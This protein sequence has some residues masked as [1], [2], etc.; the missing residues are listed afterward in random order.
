MPTHRSN[1]S[2]DGPDSR[3]I[4]P[5][6][7][8]APVQIGRYRILEHLGAGGMGVVYIALDTERNERV[9]LK[10]LQRM[11]PKGLLRLKNEFRSVA[12][13]IHPN[14]VVL[15]ELVGEGDD[16][17]FTMELVHGASFLDY[18]RGADL[19]RRTTTRFA[20]TVL[21]PT[22][23]QT[24]T[25][26]VLILDTPNPAAI[27]TPPPSKP[28]SPDCVDRLRTA[29]RQLAEGVSALHA[30]GK[31]HR[32]LK[33]SNVMV[34]S[35][36]RVV[37]LDFGLV[38]DVLPDKE[39]KRNLA[40]TPAYMAPELVLLQPAG[41]ASDWY[42]VGVMLYEALTGAVPHDSESPAKLLSDRALIIP[43]RP[44]I[45]IPGVPQDLD[46]L[47]MA[48]LNPDPAARPDAAEILARIGGPTPNPIFYKDTVPPP[49]AIDVIGRD[50]E[51]AVLEKALEVVSQGAP[52]T[53]YIGGRSGMGKSTL[54]ESFLRH[55]GARKDTLLLRG[56]CYERE[57]LPF[58]AF[59]SIIDAL[60]RF[61][62][63]LPESELRLLLPAH[64]RE[65]SRI[66]PVLLTLKG[67]DIGPAEDDR[68]RDPNELRQRAFKGFKEL[69]ARIATRKT[70]VLYIDDLQWGDI[71]SAR[72]F[73]ELFAPPN[74]PTALLLCSY[75]SEEIDK[76]PFLKKIL[77]SI[78]AQGAAR[79]IQRLEI[80]PLSFEYARTLALSL[81]GKHG[82]DAEA[83]ALSIAR[84]SGGS[85]FFI[86]Q[87]VRHAESL[88]AASSTAEQQGGEALLNAPNPKE[89]SLEELIT[90]RVTL[91]APEPRRLLEVIAV[92]G[93]PVQLGVALSAAGIG[94]GAHGLLSTLRNARLVR[95]LGVSELDTVE[96]YHDRIRESVY[97]QLSEDLRSQRHA[98]IADE[99]ERRTPE[100]A[101]RLA[102][103]FNGAGERAKASAYAQ[104][105]AEK[106]LGSLAFE[107][108][109]EFFRLALETAQDPADSPRYA[110]LH[111]ALGEALAE[112]GRGAEAAPHYFEAAKRAPSERATGLRSLGAQHLLSSGHFE[113]GRAA[114][115]PVL[116]EVGIP[117]PQTSGRALLSTLIGF[118]RLK[119]RGLSYQ[120]RPPAEISAADRTRLEACA[121]AIKGLLSF[122][123]MR[124]ASFLL[125]Y[126]RLA[127]DIGD[128]T[129][130][131]WALTLYGMV[132]MYEG[133]AKGFTQGMSL[134][135]EVERMAIT[136]ET[137]NVRANI[138]QCKGI[139]LMGITQ[140][141]EGT[142]L[143]Q[144]ALTIF[145][146]QCRGV[147]WE[148]NTAI[149]AIAE[150]LKWLGRF[151]E[152]R[153]LLPPWKRQAERLG[154]VFA[155]V[156]AQLAGANIELADGHPNAARQSAREAMRLW[157]KDTY[158]HQHWYGDRIEISSDIYDG[159]IESAEHRLT[160]T[161]RALR[162]ADLMRVQYVRIN[163]L[164]L[165]AA[166]SLARARGFRAPLLRRR[167][168][169]DA[170]T[171]A[172]LG[173]PCAQGSS[174]L[175]L[176]TLATQLGRQEEAL[177]RFKSA[178]ELFSAAGMLL[179][180][181]AVRRHMGLFIGG[182]E[183]AGQCKAALDVLR[184]QGIADPERF[185][186]II[187]QTTS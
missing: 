10:T 98:A 146:D 9:A 117:W 170:N 39:T 116:E 109:A 130:I 87:L 184:E 95:S 20:E 55:I 183:G 33:P 22:T 166:I 156:S 105:A 128:P 23:T 167:A 165:R 61:L 169:Q 145:R 91:L 101:V 168:S 127:L 50:A 72:L 12:D 45:R 140:F 40:G 16:W 48:L 134:L 182:D 144:Q 179:H 133:S 3:R 121:S 163:V 30:A 143:V 15:H 152:L 26:S 71:D 97:G 54:C 80:E 85:P 8:G 119:M 123:S 90:A 185:C 157:F 11:S 35:E 74:P 69:L 17:F 49:S 131:A 76:S 115:G 110:L 93:G 36:G 64:M 57:S 137:P 141:D 177:S 6:E 161:Y 125:R 2:S 14:L 103:H 66:F 151:N 175:I 56:R 94:L 108:A 154:N 139:G 176:G 147:D 13:I 75:R 181:A 102:F 96:S 86:E 107:R 32:D 60:A 25:P 111:E 126:T 81:M 120:L 62:E 88:D 172:K 65:L 31:L 70:L 100:D 148:C 187:V 142:K 136:R 150:S 78:P 118:I 51:L 43:E 52:S 164:Q 59:D 135:D 4:R 138:F 92:A 155:V 27:P 82:P 83:R 18:V 68:T 129:C 186:S 99:I 53:I 174:E 122:D 89:I 113:E 47:C 42:A 178:V 84:E 158:T 1:P 149:S 114:L 7:P 44:R 106:A 173:T 112:A 159:D 29:M 79:S 58:K 63:G 37:I 180:E 24:H 132:Q 19:R 124:A 67:L 162:S 38:S 46:E 171:L 21:A 34:T 160:T 77:D 73:E 28:L 104:T 153:T 5:S 41:T